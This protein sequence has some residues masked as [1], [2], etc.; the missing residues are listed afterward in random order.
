MEILC[1]VFNKY[2]TPVNADK[3]LDKPLTFCTPFIYRGLFFTC[4]QTSV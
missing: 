1:S 2:Q 3:S 4:H